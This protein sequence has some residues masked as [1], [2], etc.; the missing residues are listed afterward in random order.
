MKNILFTGGGGA[1][2]EAIFRILS[3][4]YEM[5]FAD[6]DLSAIS[7]LIPEEFRHEIP[8]AVSSD[9]IDNIN[10]LCSK[11]KIDLVIP[12]VD[13]ELIKIGNINTPLMLPDVNYVKNMLDKYTCNHI[14]TDLGIVAPKTTLISDYKSNNWSYFPCIA[15]PRSGRGSRNVY[16]IESER[17]IDAYL[18]LTGI[19][20]N[21][22]VLQEKIIG[23]EYTVLV[24]ADQ[25][26]NLHAVVPVRI[27]SKKGITISA[28]IEHNAI[29]EGACKKIHNQIPTKGCYNIQLIL[30]D[31]GA[32]FPFE[33]NPRISTTFC[34]SL[35]SGIDPI[36]IYINKHKSNVMLKYKNEIK[37]NRYWFNSFS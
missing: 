4:D 5:H 3:D 11:Y 26:A 18:S 29:I 1:G 31:D 6:A 25:D 35:E 15:K 22:S 16:I 34:M 7:P 9:F 10:T 19:N 12:G 17:Q 14:L 27:K 2:N 13:E 28:V 37:L 32:V 21:E 33:I 20:D 24:A 8:Y 36:D 30:T 23:V